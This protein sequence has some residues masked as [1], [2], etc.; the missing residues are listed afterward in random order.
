[1]YFRKE[2]KF[3]S[4]DQVGSYKTPL[5]HINVRLETARLKSRNGS[6]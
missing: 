3:A 6:R 1:M 2:E 4:K 5:N